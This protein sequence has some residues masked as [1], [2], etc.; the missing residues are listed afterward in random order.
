MNTV[1]WG[2][3]GGLP[4]YT[5]VVPRNVLSRSAPYIAVASPE[6]LQT[7]LPTI[8]V[9][10]FQNFP[11]L[12]CP[13]HTH[14]LGWT[15]LEKLSHSHCV[16][17]T[18]WIIL[19]ECH[20]NWHFSFTTLYK[21]CHRDRMVLINTFCTLNYH[22]Q[23]LFSFESSGTICKG[24][25]CFRRPLYT[26][27]KDFQENFL[28]SFQRT[29]LNIHHALISDEL[30]TFITL[31]N[32]SLTSSYSFWRYCIILVWQFRSNCSIKYMLSISYNIW[33]RITYTKK[34]FT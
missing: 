2:F 10:N 7:M 18:K 6:F 5:A 1:I 25:N 8:H 31:K 27:V 23:C 21:Y 4:Y 17:N 30:S 3:L 29:S 33:R 9:R 19:L 24:Q 15:L 34:L 32:N 12:S 26:F 16:N 14:M 11:Q 20:N 13:S 22:N 28:S